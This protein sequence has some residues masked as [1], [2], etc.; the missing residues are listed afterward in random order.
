MIS[1]RCE[2]GAAELAKSFSAPTETKS[3]RVSGNT[4][5]RGAIHLFNFAPKCCAFL[6]FKLGS[7]QPME[8]A[9]EVPLASPGSATALV[10]PWTNVRSDLAAPSIE[11]IEP[12][13]C[14]TWSSADRKKQHH[15]VPRR[16]PP[17]TGKG[18]SN[19]LGPPAHLGIT[20]G[21]K[22]RCMPQAFWGAPTSRYRRHVRPNNPEK[23]PQA[24]QH[25]SE[26][27]SIFFRN[28]R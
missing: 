19:R 22:T 3:H 27:P 7:F 15:C 26:Q 12:W 2:R 20:P 1:C 14:L 5:Y 13:N 18:L 16:M 6:V 11:L 23:R 10:R 28:V 8:A 4:V 24:R 17:F 9:T 25:G 21:E